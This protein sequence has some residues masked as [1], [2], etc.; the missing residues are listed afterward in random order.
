MILSRFSSNSMPRLGEVQAR[1]IRNLFLDSDDV[2]FQA[3]YLEITALQSRV[4]FASVLI[5]TCSKDSS[6]YKI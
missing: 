6:E 3:M 5:G 2:F 4:V 1:V